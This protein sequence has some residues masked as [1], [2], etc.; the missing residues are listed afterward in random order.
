VS[1]RASADLSAGTS[2]NATGGDAAGSS[3][4]PSVTRAGETTRTTTSPARPTTSAAPNCIGVP[5]PSISKASPA[6]SGPTMRARLAADAATPSFTP[7]SCAPL[8]RLTSADNVGTT[9]PLPAAIA[10]DP[11]AIQAAARTE[12]V[13]ARPIARMASPTRSV[14]FSPTRRTRRPT[15]TPCTTMMTNPIS[16]NS[17]PVS[18]SPHPSRASMSNANV[19]SIAENA[20][21]NTK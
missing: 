3:D 16:V 4:T 13:V 19:A 9:S 1:A 6:A 12:P 2:V 5:G 15:T 10:A 17:A 8:A 18:R 21:L 20:R 14:R 7:C 11:V